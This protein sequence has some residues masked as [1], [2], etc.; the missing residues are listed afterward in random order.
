M[1][2]HRA[3]GWPDLLILAAITGIIYGLV[4]LAG[5]WGGTLR[6]TVEIDLS[7]WALPPC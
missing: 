4:G 6:P 7:P 2:L 5:E 3:F 1:R